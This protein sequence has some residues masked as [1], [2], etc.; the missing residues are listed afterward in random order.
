M[1]NGKPGRS[2][3][4]YYGIMDVHIDA[5]MFASMLKGK[6]T[7]TRTAFDAMFELIRHVRHI[8]YLY[9]VVYDKSKIKRVN[10]HDVY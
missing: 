4:Q 6:Y 5:F 7:A 3:V 9:T 10:N 2:I 8:H 1:R